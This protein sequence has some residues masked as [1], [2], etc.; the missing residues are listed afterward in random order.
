MCF[1]PEIYGVGVYE[2]NDN[3]EYTPTALSLL[4][5]ATVGAMWMRLQAAGS[6]VGR[7]H[8]R[9]RPSTNLLSEPLALRE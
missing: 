6:S 9:V 4:N 7:A 1:L 5:T 8:N 2:V 3:V